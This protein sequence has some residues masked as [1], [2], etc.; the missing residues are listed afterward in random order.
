VSVLVSSSSVAYEVK[1]HP[2][3]T[4][5]SGSVATRRDDDGFKS[6][7]LVTAVNEK[8]KTDEE[9]LQT[10]KVKGNVIRFSYENPK[11]R[12]AHEI[13]TNYRQGFEKGGFKI[14]F[15]CVADECGAH[16]AMSRWARVTGMRYFTTEMRYFASKGSRDGED[17]YI[18]VLVA[19]ARH[20]VELVESARWRQASSRPSRSGKA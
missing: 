9:V 18:A 3:F 13:Y 6:Y 17:V 20:Q 15:A 10:L 1:G 8:G 4:P 5:Y 11:D 2:A 7:S 16:Y 14:L 12:S 19:K